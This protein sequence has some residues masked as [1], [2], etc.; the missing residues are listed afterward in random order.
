VVLEKKKK[1][2][3]WKGDFNLANQLVRVDGVAEYA[4]EEEIAEV[5]KE[6]KK[7]PGNK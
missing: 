4:T 2:G 3:K 5:P 1:G 6:K 7:K